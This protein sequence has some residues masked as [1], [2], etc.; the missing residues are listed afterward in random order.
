MNLLD[1]IDAPKIENAGDKN[2]GALEERWEWILAFMVLEDMFV[3]EMLLAMEKHG[4]KAIPTLGIAVKDMRLVLAYN[5]DFVRKLSDPEL[6]F[7]VSHEIYHAVFHHCTRRA[8]EDKK[9]HGLW[10]KA[11]DL[12][13]NSLLVQDGNRHMPKGDNKGIMPKDFG[14]EDKLSMEQYLQALRDKGG[15]EDSGYGQI[16]EDGELGGGF[17]SHDDW[18]ESEIAREI[19]RNKV[20]QIMRNERVW[21]NMPGDMKA[22]I[23]A[24]QRSTV[25]WRKYLRRHLGHLITSKSQP[26]FKRPN[27]RFG[28]PFSGTKKFHCDRKLVAIDTSGSVSDDDLEQFLAE[29]NKL[30]EIQPVDLQLFD[31]TLQGKIVPFSK[32]CGKYKFSG[33]GGTCFTPVFELAEK[34]RYQSLII[35]T[36]GFA[37]QPPKPRFVKDVLW[38]LTA[39]GKSPVDWGKVVKIVPKGTPTE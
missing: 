23:A 33:R 34:L 39:E 30:S 6:R 15:E 22:M 20:E 36:D 3:H 14:F 16:G 26:T 25:A 37:E 17:D 27:R 28:F 8:P 2:F 5:P 19:I 29:I 11:A 10:N 21:G 1:I 31:H 4:T 7:V 9:E 24:A 38:V 12:A 35:L 32:K 18:E 13:I